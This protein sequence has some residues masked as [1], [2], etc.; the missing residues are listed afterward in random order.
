MSD[1]CGNSCFPLKQLFPGDDVLEQTG[2]NVKKQLDKRR[3]RRLDRTDQRQNEG[4][5]PKHLNYIHRL[6]LLLLFEL[7]PHE[8][9]PINT[10]IDEPINR[11]ID[12]HHHVGVTV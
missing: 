5:E 6:E 2:S 4:A 3:R 9:E 11:S 12:D 7:R 10:S 1:G 8:Y